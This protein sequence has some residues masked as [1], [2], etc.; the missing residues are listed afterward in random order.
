MNGKI[1]VIGAGSWGTTLANILANKG[2]QTNLWVYE[3][4]LAQ[5]IE[6]KRENPIYLPEISLSELICPT[7]SLEEAVSDCREIVFVVPSH[8][9]RQVISQLGSLISKDSIIISSTKGIENETLMTMSK[10]FQEVLPWINMDNFVS[11]SGPTFAKEVSQKLPTAVTVASKNKK[12]AEHA[13]NIFSTSSFRVYTNND[14]IGVELGGALKNVIAIAAG[15]SDGLEFGNNARAALITRGLAE[16]SRLGQTMG[17]NLLTFSGLAGLGDLV[18]TCTGNLS[19]NRTV[20][21]KLG[22]GMKL[23]DIL[24]QMQMVAE[25]VKTTKSVI[26]LAQKYSIDMPITQQVYSILYEDKDPQLAVTEL[27]NRDLKNE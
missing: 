3:K 5:L 9:A 2:Y 6:K 20:G 19:R 4:D 17:A 24:A 14:V 21:L 1:A 23:R 27:M 10:V 18:L 7:S 12:I 11:L 8:A 15:V 25:G 13:Q 16:I 22:Q 26:G